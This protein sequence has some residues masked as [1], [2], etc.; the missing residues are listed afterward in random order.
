[1]LVMGL[2][3]GSTIKLKQTTPSYVVQIGFTQLAVDREIAR[4][5]ILKVT[6]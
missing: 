5:I 1:M 6:S 4:N 2:L 3:P